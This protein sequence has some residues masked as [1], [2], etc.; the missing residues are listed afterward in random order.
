MA[1]AVIERLAR[2]I[3]PAAL[4]AMLNGVNVDL[5]S[6]A[7][8]IASAAAM[9][10]TIGDPEVTIEARYDAATEVRRLIIIRTHHGTPHITAIDSD[11]LATG[12]RR[13]I[14]RAHV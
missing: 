1:E 5:D 13:E 12:G 10:A 2:A 3:E 9:A 4:R 8:A 14:G 7:A 6:E 11:F